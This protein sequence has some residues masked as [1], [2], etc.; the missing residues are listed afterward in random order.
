MTKKQHSK[1]YSNISV[2]SVDNLYLNQARYMPPYSNLVKSPKS[3]EKWKIAADKEKVPKPSPS[4]EGKDVLRKIEILKFGEYAANVSIHDLG[5]WDSA[6]DVKIMRNASVGFSSL[7][8][9]R[10]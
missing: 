4:K 1:S 7:K 10:K 6:S 3:L 9:H 8:F 2:Q 5:G